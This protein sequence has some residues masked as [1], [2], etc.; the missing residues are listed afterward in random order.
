VDRKKKI[1]KMIIQYF[2]VILL[3][4]IFSQSLNNLALPRVSVVNGKS[5]SLQMNIQKEGTIAARKSEQIYATFSGIIDKIF[6][7]TNKTVKKGDP[8]IKLDEKELNERFIQEEGNYKKAKLNY[9][10]AKAQYEN[11]EGLEKELKAVEKASEELEK[12]KVYYENNIVSKE[13]FEKAADTLKDA[14]DAYNKKKKN[15]PI[16]E[17]KAQNSLVESEMEYKLKEITFKEIQK[18]VANKGILTAPIDGVVKNISKKEGERINKDETILALTDP[19]SGYE[20]KFSIKKDIAK[21][22]KIGENLNI[23]FKGLDDLKV[24]S[25]IT[26]IANNKE[27]PSQIKDVTLSFENEGLKGDEFATIRETK[28]TTKYDVVVPNTAIGKEQNGRKFVWI[29]RK[30][31]KPLGK[32]YYVNKRYVN[33]G[34]SDLNNTAIK[35]GLDKYE[36]FVQ[37]DTGVDLKENGRVLKK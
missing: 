13:E 27:E 30:E 33:T 17:L 15:Q 22:L 10:I 8:L 23:T 28:S 18:I 16:E 34:E 32:E 9:E 36:E 21:Y 6:V 37:D 29:I 12:K 11:Q 5:T 2:G 19:S 3:F 31:D 7:Q 20:L 25:K 4:T 26:D 1:K 14:E 35:S 24:E